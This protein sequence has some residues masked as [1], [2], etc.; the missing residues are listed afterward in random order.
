MKKLYILSLFALFSISPF[1]GQELFTCYDEYRKVFENRGA[2][3]VKDGIH[4]DV[5][6]TIRK[7]KET[8]CYV[9]TVTIKQGDVVEIAIYFEDNTKEVLTYEFTDKSSWSIYNGI[10]KT[11]VTDKEEKIN[12]MFTDMIKPKRKEFK[13]APKP[14]F[15]LN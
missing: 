10:S 4:D 11:R 5:I 6:L 2:F 14:K 15:D 1:F 9:C 8:E 13:K 7:D 3:E 12:I